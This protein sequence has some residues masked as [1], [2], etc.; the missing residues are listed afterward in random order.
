MIGTSCFLWLQRIEDIWVTLLLLFKLLHCHVFP[1]TVNY[2]GKLDDYLSKC[3]VANQP[4]KPHMPLVLPSWLEIP[5]SS[6]LLLI[7]TFLRC[8]ALVPQFSNC[9]RGQCDQQ[10]E[11]GR[12]ASLLRQVSKLP[13][14]IHRNNHCKAGTQPQSRVSQ[15][16]PLHP[17]SKLQPLPAQPRSV[18]AM[19]VKLFLT[20]LRNFVRNI[21]VI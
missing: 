18:L 17:L 21:V 20:C 9:P 19:E 6:P 8:F 12:K 11:F 2:G 7:Y 10:E 16:V 14:V 3:P 1:I 5:S 4:P 13:E 15:P